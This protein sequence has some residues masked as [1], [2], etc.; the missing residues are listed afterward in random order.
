MDCFRFP[1]MVVFQIYFFNK[2]F[3]SAYFTLN[4]IFTLCQ[5]IIIVFIIF[6]IFP[7]ILF[8]DLVSMNLI[9]YHLYLLLYHLRK[10]FHFVFFIIITIMNLLL[11]LTLVFQMVCS[12]CL[13]SLTYQ[14]PFNVTQVTNFL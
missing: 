11:I 10:L 12:N 3:L 5:L 2:D 6:L 7:S 13:N 9:H 14:G 8:F 4:F 1:I